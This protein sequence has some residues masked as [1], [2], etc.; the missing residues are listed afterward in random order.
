MPGMKFVVTAIWDEDACVYL[1]QSDIT[2][3]HIEA[4]TREE[5]EAVLMDM[6]PA[7][8]V[9][10]HMSKADFIGKSV[11]DLIPAIFAN[12]SDGRLAMA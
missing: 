5:F 8:V 9:E 6:A 1:S 12:F 3:L 10:N 11:V 7:L 2:G 4:A